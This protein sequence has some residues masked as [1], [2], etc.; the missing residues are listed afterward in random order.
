MIA[1]SSV[2]TESVNKPFPQVLPRLCSTV[3]NSKTGG[4]QQRNSERKFVQNTVLSVT[5]WI[6][7]IC[8]GS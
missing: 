8:K 4:K 7:N 2:E 5:P 1:A 6:K 3:V